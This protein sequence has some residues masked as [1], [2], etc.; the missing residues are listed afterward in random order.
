M[1]RDTTTDA[2]YLQPDGAIDGTAGVA[3]RRTGA[4]LQLR[5]DWRASDRVAFAAEFVDFRIDD[6]IRAAGGS[7]SRYASIE[8]VVTW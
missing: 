4:Y 7:N 5:A 8:A 1:W 3:G 2:V 6:A